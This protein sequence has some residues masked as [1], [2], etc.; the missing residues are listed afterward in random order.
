MCARFQSDPKESHLQAVKRII[1][2]L[3]GT[4][5]LGLWYPRHTNFD[6]V[7][8]SDADFAACTIDRKSTSGTCHF[9]GSRLVSWACKKQASVSTS[10]TEAE[11]IAAGSCCAQILWIKQ[12]LEDY[13]VQ[14]VQT[15]IYCD[16]TSAISVSHNP[17]MHSK[18][19]HIDI[20]Y[21]FLKDHVEKGNILL[22]YISTELQL[23]DILTKALDSSRFAFLRGELGMI[24]LNA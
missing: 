7:G 12:Q 3:V 24:D 17:V 1:R 23:A 11:Y 10:T 19:K 20:R 18:T 16:N 8:Y 5:N 9:L 13:N 6:L 4:A 15:P 21:H 2:Y 22:Q 14:I